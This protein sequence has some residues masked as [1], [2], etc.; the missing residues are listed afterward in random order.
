MGSRGRCQSFP[1]SRTDEWDCD[2][3]TVCSDGD[4]C[5]KSTRSSDGESFS[6]A[7][8]ADCEESSP[9]PSHYMTIP[10]LTMVAVPLYSKTSCTALQP[11]KSSAS[12]TASPVELVDRPMPTLKAQK[13]VRRRRRRGELRVAECLQQLQQ[14]DPQ[15]VLRLN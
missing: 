12:A 10:M 2:A 7:S 9:W 13:S 14:Q 3:S 8:S 15:C 5:M 6:S 11:T 4:D 1:H